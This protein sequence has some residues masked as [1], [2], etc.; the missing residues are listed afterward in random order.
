ML[1]LG[2]LPH[3]LGVAVALSVGIWERKREVGK[4]TICRSKAWLP[5]RQH[6]GCDFAVSSSFAAAIS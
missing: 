4:G 3:A 5:S 6:P 1:S 2:M